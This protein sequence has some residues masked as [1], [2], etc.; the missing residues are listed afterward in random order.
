[1]ENKN[2]YEMELHEVSEVADDHSNNSDF[3]ATRVPGGWIYT[4]WFEGTPVNSV[5]VPFNNE[6]KP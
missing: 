3:L 2:L 6:F 5:F 1:M 4:L